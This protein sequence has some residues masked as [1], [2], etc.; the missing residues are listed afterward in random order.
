MPETLKIKVN[1]RTARVREN[2]HGETYISTDIVINDKLFELETRN[3]L[4][5]LWDS[6]AQRHKSY[7]IVK[8]SFINYHVS[9]DF[10]HSTPWSDSF[11]E[12]I[13]HD[14]QVSSQSELINFHHSILNNLSN[15]IVILRDL[16]SAS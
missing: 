5:W 6:N 16:K 3:G 10:R 4:G 11:I 8:T 13:V 14:N 2:S 9:G 1:G 12:T 7:P 15:S